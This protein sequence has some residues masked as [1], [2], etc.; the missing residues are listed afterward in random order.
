MEE[1][2][3]IYHY[4][5]RLKHSK[6][7]RERRQEIIRNRYSNIDKPG[8]NISNFDT[9]RVFTRS[10]SNRID[11]VYTVCFWSGL[12]VSIKKVD[13]KKD[14]R[15]IKP[16]A[17]LRILRLLNTGTGISSILRILK[18]GV[19]QLINVDSMLVYF[20]IFLA[21]LEI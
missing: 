13:H 15:I 21:I 1:S 17:L 11:F 7:E 9:P 3:L 19:P 4:L 18:Y 10:P 6:R 20:W 2:V 16:L 8:L 12:F 5:L 14:V